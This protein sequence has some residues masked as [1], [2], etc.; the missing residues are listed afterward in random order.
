MV[1]QIVRDPI[2]LRVKS[3]PAGPEDME[4]VQD[5][6]DTLK[7]NSDRCVGMAANMIGVTRTILAAQIAGKYKIMI[8]PVITSHSTEYTETEEGCLSLSGTRPVK[9]YKK[10]SV[11]Y[12]DEQFRERKGT[13]RDFEAQIIQHEIDHFSGILI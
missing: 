3:E 12:L 7:A 13:F 4:T 8:N 11:T 9:R 1:K 10:I 5:L 6:L 2:F